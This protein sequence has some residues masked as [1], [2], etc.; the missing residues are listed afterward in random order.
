MN[1]L[2]VHIFSPQFSFLVHKTHTHTCVLD[3][4]VSINGKN[5]KHFMATQKVRTALNTAKLL[6]MWTKM[7]QREQ[8]SNWF[9][10]FQIEKKMRKETNA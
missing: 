8:K 4:I 6:K 7:K 9:E 1:L 10:A 5:V 2:G 3:D